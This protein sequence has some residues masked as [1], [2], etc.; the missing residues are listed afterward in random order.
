MGQRGN[1]FF[2]CGLLAGITDRHIAIRDLTA[3]PDDLCN[4]L[5]YSSDR[6]K[7]YSISWIDDPF[8]QIALVFGVV[9]CCVLC[10]GVCTLLLSCGGPVA[11]VY[12]RGRRVAPTPG[13]HPAAEARKPLSQ[14]DLHDADNAEF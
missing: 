2:F 9:G 1:A 8:N 6:A 3:G 11:S 10:C 5:I 14:P 13:E 4:S 7:R 12:H